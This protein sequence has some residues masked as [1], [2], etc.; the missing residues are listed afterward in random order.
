M[1]DHIQPDAP[2]PRQLRAACGQVQPGPSPSPFPAADSGPPH[3]VQA[4]DRYHD[5]RSLAH[6]LRFSTRTLNRLMAAGSLPPPDLVIG[7][8][9]RWSPRTVEKWLRSRPRL[10][11]RKGSSRAV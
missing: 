3:P 8:S 11:G 2:N 4:T 1:P 6:Y 5:R 9:P 10:P 7:K